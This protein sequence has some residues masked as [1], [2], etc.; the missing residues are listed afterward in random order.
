M[1][2]ADR[3]EVA[4]LPEGELL[5]KASPR[6]YDALTFTLATGDAEWIDS[7]HETIEGIRL[8]K[9]DLPG[10]FTSLG[11]SNVSCT[12]FCKS[13][14]SMNTA[15]AHAMSKCSSSTH[16]S[17]WSNGTVVS[18]WRNRG[19][20]EERTAPVPFPEGAGRVP[21]NASMPA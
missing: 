14:C 8:I 16:T 17:P 20:A 15:N 19:W 9:R 3:P 5:A 2:A 13:A 1:D 12:S 7:A 10:V 6:I 4:G 18:R 11:V 21:R